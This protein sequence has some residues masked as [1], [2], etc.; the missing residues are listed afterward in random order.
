MPHR[1]RKCEQ[2]VV[3]SHRPLK[4]A[5]DR[6]FRANGLRGHAGQG[7]EQSGRPGRAPDR[8]PVLGLVG[9]RDTYRAARGSAESGAEKASLAP[10]PTQ[11]VSGVYQAPAQMACGVDDLLHW[12]ATCRRAPLPCATAARLVRCPQPTVH[13]CESAAGADSRGWQEAAPVRG[14]DFVPTPASAI[15]AGALR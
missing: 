1:D 3:I 7:W 4:Q 2:G 9:C 13:T 10:Q 8:G 14:L 11:E 12:R 15:E 6:L 5:T